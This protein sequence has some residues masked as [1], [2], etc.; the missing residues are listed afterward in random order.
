MIFVLVL[1]FCT[2]VDTLNGKSYFEQCYLSHPRKSDSYWL[3]L[4]AF[5]LS[6]DFFSKSTFSKNSFRNTTSVTN[7]LDP[8][9][10]RHAVGP[11]LGTNCLQKVS[12]DD[13]IR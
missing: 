13:A 8:D 5:L 11:D 3:I 12:P 4:H 9:Q 2:L 7:S 6:A 1:S 10:A